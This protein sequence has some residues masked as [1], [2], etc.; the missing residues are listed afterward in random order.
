MTQAG[1]TPHYTVSDHV[2]ALHSHLGCPFLDAVIVNN[3]AI[4]EAIR[5]RYEEERAE[6]VRDDSSGLGVQVI[7]DNIVTYDDGVIRHNTTK[8]ASL[9]LGLLPRR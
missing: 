3:G 4:P 5:R 1:E 8:V 6:P 7:H 2:K 9:L